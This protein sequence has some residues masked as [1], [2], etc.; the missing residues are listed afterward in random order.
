M[1]AADVVIVGAGAVGVSIAYHLAERRAGRIIVLE[2]NLVGS[3]I[4]AKGTGGVRLQFS[5]AVNIRLSQ[6]AVPFFEQFADRF[7]V[8][9][10]YERRGYLFVARDAERHAA[11]RRNLELQQQLGVPS[12]ELS[13][14]EV[15]ELVPY[16]RADDLV[17]AAYCA[18]D[19]RVNSRKVVG[20]LTERARALGVEFREWMAVTALLREGERVVGLET[21]AGPIS[22]PV[23][24]NACGPWSAALAAMA[25][26]DLP[27]KPHRRQQFLTEATDAVP[28]PTPLIIDTDGSFS[29][30]SLGDQIRM[31]M[32][33]PGEPSGW[34]DR[35]EWDLASTARQ[36]LAHRAP[37]LGELQVV[38]GYAC[39][40]DM[41][42]G[43]HAIIGWAPGAP[44]M[45]LANGFSGHGFMHSPI[46]G[47]LVAELI[48]DGSAHTVDIAAL[49]PSRFAEGQP[50]KEGLTIV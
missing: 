20:V 16:L 24:V 15:G 35:V 36:R 49:R 33:R 50:I 43:A 23:V 30:H 21:A 44:G 7:G 47:R 19:G 42:P 38:S 18:G 41:T 4:T 10:E 5:T 27:V 8:D 48:L 32:T 34:D 3:G 46:V 29:F 28:K 39:L 37:V 22:T 13:P 6:Q 2:R 12:R 11:F 26:V 25:G 40:L 1:E 14:A 9:P 31:G 45:L 17:G